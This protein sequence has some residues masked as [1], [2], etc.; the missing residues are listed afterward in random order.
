[1]N[2]SEEQLYSA[3]SLKN[4]GYLVLLWPFHELG[5]K[6]LFY[7]LDEIFRLKKKGTKLYKS[8]CEI[9]KD[10]R[11]PAWLHQGQIVPDPSDGLL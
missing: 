6:G 9:R 8:T 2:A 7:H 11:Q 3:V 1:M 10:P 4:V 5:E